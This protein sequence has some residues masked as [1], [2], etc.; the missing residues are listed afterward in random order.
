MIEID[1]I[2]LLR[3]S[4]SVLTG[5][6]DPPGTMDMKAFLLQ[7]FSEVDRKQVNSLTEV[8]LLLTIRVSFA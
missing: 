7:K 8:M 4:L 6:G 1:P 5:I 2:F 3:F